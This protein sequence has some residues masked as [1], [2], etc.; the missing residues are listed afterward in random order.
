MLY[1]SPAREGPMERRTRITPGR[2]DR[3]RSLVTFD[4]DVIAG[5]IAAVA[6]LVLHLLHIVERDVLLFIAVVLVALL[7]IRDI[8][9]ERS[10]EQVRADIERAADA[11]ARIDT[12]LSPADTILLGPARLRE[13]TEDFCRR[14]VGEMTWFHVCLLMFRPQSLFD[15]L[16][17]PAIENPAVG[18]IQ[19]ILDRAQQTLWDEHVVP[20]L[21]Q[22][23]GR[24]KVQPPYWTT[25]DQ[26][27][28]AIIAETRPT[29]RTES[30]LSFWGE[31]FMSHHAGHDIP[32]YV[33]LVQGHSELVSHLLELARR[34]RATA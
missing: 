17:R 27:V 15:S 21:E 32:R 16:L 9:R 6:A 29:G 11:I 33:F 3:W 34:H 19:F 22:C 8:R 30:L 14:A 4:W 20:K 31:P 25:I 5:L 13:D 24:D 1:R 10:D 23:R 12:H 26:N 28:S 7:L 18:S 2:G